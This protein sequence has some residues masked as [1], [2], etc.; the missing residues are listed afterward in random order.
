MV[1]DR[2]LPQD[3]SDEH[4]MVCVWG[5]TTTAPTSTTVAPPTTTLQP[6]TA[7]PASTA[8]ANLLFNA[9]F[10]PAFNTQ[11]F[12]DK[13]RIYF[14]D[15]SLIVVLDHQYSADAVQFHLQSDT[16]AM[17]SYEANTLNSMS[18]ADLLATFGITTLSS[19]PFTPAVAPPSSGDPLTPGAIGGI[20]AACVVFAAVL[21]AVKVTRTRT[22]KEVEH[23][24]MNYI[25]VDSSM[26]V[27]L[28]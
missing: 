28:Q 15:N 26:N 22:P 23:V 24:N 1:S 18:P 12:Q 2:T 14:T 10:T 16:P 25:A 17:E 19:A 6:T 21:I 27:V 20:C 5:G 13:L 8:L 3:C 9:T 4:A 11:A 7:V